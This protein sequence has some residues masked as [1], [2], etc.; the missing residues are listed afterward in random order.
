MTN[1]VEICSKLSH[2]IN[3]FVFVFLEK[4]I[5]FIFFVFV[6]LTKNIY[7]R[8]RTVLEEIWNVLLIKNKLLVLFLI[9][10]VV[11][12]Y[13]FIFWLLLVHVHS[14]F[15]YLLPRGMRKTSTEEYMAKMYTQML[16][17]CLLRL[18]HMFGFEINNHGRTD[19]QLFLQRIIQDFLGKN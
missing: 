8:E 11:Q 13:L 12:V 15:Q 7:L 10:R 19:C 5:S 4:H 9:D 16:L 3:F 2:F 1:H 18:A 17:Y 6:F 14:A